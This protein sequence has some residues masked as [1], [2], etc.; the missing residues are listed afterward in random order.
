MAETNT[1][2]AKV[3]VG[4]M[5][6][7]LAGKVREIREEKGLGYAELS[8]RAGGRLADLAFRRIENGQRR[9]DVDD[10]FVLGQALGVPP[11]DLLGFGVATE[12]SVDPQRDLDEAE[13]Q[14]RH[15]RS[16]EERVAA[17]EARLGS[18]G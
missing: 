16:L 15:M 1:G 18:D 13:A 14:D 11:V 5:G 7:Y 2:R 17:L 9:V 4:P 10:L 3:V 8:R 12:V 6:E